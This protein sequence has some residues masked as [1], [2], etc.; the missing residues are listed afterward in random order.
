MYACISLIFIVSNSTASKSS[1]VVALV[2]L[3]AI[4]ETLAE[5]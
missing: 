4:V 5:P 2:F 1:N 3:L